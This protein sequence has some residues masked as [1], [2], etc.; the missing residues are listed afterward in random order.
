MKFGSAK[1]S[2]TLEEARPLAVQHWQ[3][4]TYLKDIEFIPDYQ[5]YLKLEELGMTRSFSA[6]TDDGI[7]IGY[8][9]FLLQGAFY[10]KSLIQALQVCLFVD[11]SHRGIAPYF[12]NACDDQLKQ[13][14]IFEVLHQSPSL[15]DLSILFHHLGYQEIQKVY[16][17]RL[18]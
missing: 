13:E 10:N 15:K 12:F 18:N 6:R 4:I 11:K 16:S 9:V 14:G 8:A 1:I 3:E 2:E 7:L 5:Q 17:K